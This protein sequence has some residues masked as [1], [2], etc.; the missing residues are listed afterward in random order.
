MWLPCLTWGSSFTGVITCTFFLLSLKLMEPKISLPQ[1]QTNQN[2]FPFF[3]CFFS[4]LLQTPI[5]GHLFIKKITWAQVSRSSTLSR[6]LVR[7]A[8]NV[9]L[10]HMLGHSPPANTPR[11]SPSKVC[12][13]IN[14]QAFSTN[15]LIPDTSQAKSRTTANWLV[16]FQATMWYV[17]KAW[18]MK[19][20]HTKK[21]KW[22]DIWQCTHLAA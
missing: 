8:Q 11:L 5:F 20:N 13:K 18:W 2:K 1:N 4:L 10:H 15:K 17:H 6:S 22:T 9:H 16:S 7:F 3:R 14:K 12:N 19:Q 21:R